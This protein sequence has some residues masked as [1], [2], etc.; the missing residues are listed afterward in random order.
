VYVTHDQIEALALSDRIAV[1]RGGRIVQVGTPK[2]IYETPADPFVAD[3][4]GTS[5][6]FH[7][8]AEPA[9]GGTDH[10][11][12]R[13]ERGRPLVVRT[14]R[15]IAPGTRVVVAVR[16]EKVR[17][18]DA[19]AADTGTEPNI[20]QAHVAERSYVGSR[21]QYQ[22]EV[23]GAVLRV[24]TPTELPLPTVW[25]SIPPDSCAV[26]PQDEVAGQEVSR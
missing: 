3:F 17:L 13:V 16:P 21:Y 15:S 23:A 8:V 18:L 14:P 7:G 1:M 26:F 22:L 19:R 4:I 11:A 2:A 20:L 10:L 6:F 25:V 5:S 12:V 24:E 9:D